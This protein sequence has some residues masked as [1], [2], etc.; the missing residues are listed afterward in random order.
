[1][2]AMPLPVLIIGG[3][4]VLGGCLLADE[5]GLDLLVAGRPKG[6]AAAFCSGIEGRLQPELFDRNV[7]VDVQLARL[8]PDIVVDAAG[9]FQFYGDNPYRVALAALCDAH[10]T[11]FIL[12]GGAFDAALRFSRYRFQN[13]NDKEKRQ[14]A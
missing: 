8:R 14:I 11:T 6:K 5:P 7:G 9:P 10:Q 2:S 4:G 3:Y 1:M 13:E 12:G